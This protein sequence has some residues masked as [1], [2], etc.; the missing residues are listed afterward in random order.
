MKNTNITPTVECGLIIAVAI[1]LGLIST[2]LPVI[3]TLIDFFWALPFAIL[4]VRLGLRKATY[5]LMATIILL[6]LFIG[7]IFT[8]RLALSFG[9]SGLALGFAIQKNLSAVK[10]FLLTLIVSFTAQIISIILLLF[11][12]D[13][14]F[15]EMQVEMVKETFDETFAMYESLGVDQ[16]QIQQAKSQVEPAISLLN[17]L[18]PTLLLLIAL[19]NTLI[20]FYSAKFIFPKIN[21]S[22]PKFPPFAQWKFPIAFVYLMIIAMLG[23]YWGST[24]NL[25]LLY[26]VSLNANILS[27]CVG[28]VQGMSVLSFMADRLNISKLVRRIFCVFLLFNFML[29]QI[30]AFT[31]LFDMFFDYRR[32]FSDRK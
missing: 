28:F 14:N 29:F 2:Y 18:M 8:I 21:L 9:F 7:P 10:I 15:F 23:L 6:S 11:V 17:M 31:G 4:T 3:G 19:I 32:R 12:M 13:I 16:S 22:M 27:T 20:C 30:I 5:A 24:R 26:S 1:I 25:N